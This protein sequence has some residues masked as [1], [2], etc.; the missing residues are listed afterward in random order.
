MLQ[1]SS[2]TVQY[3]NKS[4]VWLHCCMFITKNR[5]VK[6]VFF[7]KPSESIVLEGV[8][9]KKKK[10]LVAVGTSFSTCRKILGIFNVYEKKEFFNDGKCQLVLWK[11]ENLKYFFPF[12]S[13]IYQQIFQSYYYN[14]IIQEVSVWSY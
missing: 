1:S 11:S 3:Q 9:S 2:A 12:C 7:K 5:I 4:S 10:K 14:L 13:G 6:T 8:F